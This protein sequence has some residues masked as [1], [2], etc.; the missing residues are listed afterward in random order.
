MKSYP[1]LEIPIVERSHAKHWAD[2]RLEWKNAGFHVVIGDVL[3]E[4][5]CGEKI[6]YVYT[7][8]NAVNDCTA[9]V[10]RCCI[11]RFGEDSPLVTKDTMMACLNRIYQDNERGQNLELYKYIR[12]HNIFTP[13]ELNFVYSTMRKANLTRRQ[14]Q[15]RVA[16]NK[17]IIAHFFRT[18]S[19][20]T[21]LQ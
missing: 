8:H 11:K 3:D 1:P 2:A 6:R 16:L 18:N 15:W 19:S 7:I 13:R 20:P 10:G 17:K 14:M 5:I 9:D 21:N 12:D 4:C